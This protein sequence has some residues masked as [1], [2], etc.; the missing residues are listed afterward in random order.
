MITRD[1]AR[2]CAEAEVASFP[3]EVRS[4]TQHCLLDWIGVA[5]SGAS[6]PLVEMVATEVLEQG[7]SPQA[8]LLGR[9]AQVSTQQAALVNGTASHALDYDDVH[10]ILVGHPTVVIVPALLALAEHRGAS[11]RE[12]IEAFVAGYET[13]ARI[14]ALVNPGHYERGFHATATVG[15]F[16]SAAA[17]ARLMGL[18]DA[19]TAHALGIAGTQAAGLKS[20]FG[21]MCKP[22]HAGKASQNGLLAASL[23]AR[24]FES[25]TDVLECAQGFAAT[26]SENFNVEAAIAD[27]P[28][29][30]HL[31]ANLF[32]YHAA[33][34]LTHAAIECALRIRETLLQKVDALD[35]I[36]ITVH[37][38]CDSVCNI[39]TPTTGLEAKFSLRMT[40]AYALAGIDTAAIASYT[41]E[42][43]T[44]PTLV[45]L[46]DRARVEFDPALDRMQT[47]LSVA[48]TDG[49]L[50]EEFHDSG[51]AMA[52]LDAQGARLS[53]KFHALVDPI[54]GNQ[55]A[56]KIE[57][58]VSNLESIDN[59]AD[60]VAPLAG[61][62]H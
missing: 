60:L 16:G 36:V 40:V 32:K 12:F 61:P 8:T 22:L 43:C 42:S 31:R 14:G 28:G 34:Y 18:D 5:V 53:A 41:D 51:I 29:G 48:L 11:G 35:K 49:T 13:I 37:P 38:G 15:S 45:A 26:Q 10:P 23:A 54:F 44:D 52:D 57:A 19:Q 20:M 2:I 39:P 3:D 46:R 58:A 1:L 62:R 56:A 50:L 9:G 59:I 21:T 47:R 25:R 55:A 6:D 4:L 7:G 30:Y 27:P 17:C 33:C 24:G